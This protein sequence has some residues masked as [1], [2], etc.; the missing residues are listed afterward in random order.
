[1]PGAASVREPESVVF[2]AKAGV[3]ITVP[4]PPTVLLTLFGSTLPLTLTKVK[5]LPPLTLTAP[6]P[7]EP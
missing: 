3:E 1:M 5:K 7:T 2:T 4:S 6:V